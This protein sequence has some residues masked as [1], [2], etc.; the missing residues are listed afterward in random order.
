MN[1]LRTYSKKEL[2]FLKSLEYLSG[3][4]LKDLLAGF[5]ELDVLLEPEDLE[6]FEKLERNKIDST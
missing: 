6:K 5:T 4:E 2:I 1:E 3:Y